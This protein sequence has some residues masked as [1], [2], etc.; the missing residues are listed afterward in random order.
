VAEALHTLS[1][2]FVSSFLLGAAAWPREAADE[3]RMFGYASESAHMS[4]FV[5][6][7]GRI[8]E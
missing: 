6:V 2:M 5:I 7:R 8:S 1:D 4:I 3:I